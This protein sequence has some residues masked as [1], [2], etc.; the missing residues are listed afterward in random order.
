MHVHVASSSFFL[1]L[2][3][4]THVHVHTRPSTCQIYLFNVGQP[5]P[6]GGRI[7]MEYNYVEERSQG[8][9]VCYAH[10]CK[11]RLDDGHE[12]EVNIFFKSLG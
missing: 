3:P 10:T 4:N 5:L 2:N 6:D 11:Q 12:A 7:A 9:S 1:C 8:D